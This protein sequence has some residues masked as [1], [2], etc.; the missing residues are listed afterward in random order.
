MV[1]FKIPK[2]I[3][4]NYDVKSPTTTATSVLFLCGKTQNN[5]FIIYFI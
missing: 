4:I 1:I 3:D 5:L 2:V